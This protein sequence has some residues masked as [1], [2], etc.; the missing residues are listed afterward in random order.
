VSTSCANGADGDLPSFSGALRRAIRALEDHGDV[1]EVRL[2]SVDPTNLNLSFR[3][4]V[5]LPLREGPVSPSGVRREEPVTLELPREFPLDV[6]R[7]F[8]RQDFD[9]RHPHL[10]PGPPTRPPEPCLVDGDPREIVLTRGGMTALV[11]Q[12]LLWLERASRQSLIDFSQGWEPVRRDRLGSVLW[13]QGGALRTLATSTRGGSHCFLAWTETERDRRGVARTYVVLPAPLK[14]LSVQKAAD[15]LSVPDTSAV[16]GVVLVIAPGRSDSGE[17]FVADRYLPESVANMADLRSRAHEVG[18]GESLDRRLDEFGR[19]L[20]ARRPRLPFTLAVVL[21]ARRPVPL[22]GTSSE[23]ELCPYVLSV[24]RAE[25]LQQEAAATVDPLGHTETVSPGLLKEVSG[26]AK[27]APARWSLVGAGSLGSKLALHGARAAHPPDIIVDPK[28]LLPHNYARHA[29]CPEPIDTFVPS[30]RFKSDRLAMA[31][32]DFGRAPSSV[33]EDV[34]TLLDTE[35]GRR[36]LA[37]D[38]V[39]VV[40]ETTGSVAVRE[41]LAHVRW[42]AA[43]PRMIG[44]CL[45]GAG[46][47][48]LLAAEGVAGGATLDELMGELYLALLTDPE[49]AAVVHGAE[50]V[51]LPVGQGCA[52]RT[53]VLSDARLSALAAPLAVALSEAL[54]EVPPRAGRVRFGVLETDGLGQ[55]WSSLD[56][57]PYETA[58][59]PP[60]SATT[61]RIARRAADAI[62]RDV[63]AHPGV[64]TGSVLVGRYSEI[65]Q[66]FQ[67]LDVRAAPPGSVR[68]P[69]R[70]TLAPDGLLE[71]QRTLDRDSHGT[72]RLIGTWHSHPR[73][74]GASAIDRATA[75]RLG[76][77]QLPPTVLLIRTPERFRFVASDDVGEEPRSLRLARSVNDHNEDDSR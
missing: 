70:F 25:D 56:V 51:N 74:T 21:L 8:L 45:L 40:V 4:I 3:A 35:D 29:L 16:L 41:R 58:T 60:G 28:R 26:T 13:C 66:C 39:R 69:A 24:G 5:P 20:H 44:S 73:D 47:V 6:P 7:F 27:L 76:D 33:A 31:I 46:R 2:E 11:D 48:A 64:E 67:V 65:G 75:R 1:L 22:V 32:G 15:A 43:R 57:P 77:L 17:A 71:L 42:T 63:A 23:I 49:I 18:C 36:R 37:P 38:D 10:Q 9:R 12:L 19:L 59:A 62:E 54:A 53:F 30:A 55:R 50:A 34:L 61:V 72:L 52:S 14:A 68:E